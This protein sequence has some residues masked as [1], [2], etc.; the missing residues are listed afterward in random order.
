MEVFEKVRVGTWLEEN[1][2]PLQQHC[3]QYM[4]NRSVLK[5]K[6]LP[7]GDQHVE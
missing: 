4:P 3:S 6:C 5:S 7:G 2:V 1:L